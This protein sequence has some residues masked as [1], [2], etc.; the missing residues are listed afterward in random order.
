VDHTSTYRSYFGEAAACNELRELLQDVLDVDA[1]A[2]T[3]RADD[4]LGQKSSKHSREWATIQ[5]IARPTYQEEPIDF[6]NV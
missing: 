5:P 3:S 4:D 2:M 1:P 6:A